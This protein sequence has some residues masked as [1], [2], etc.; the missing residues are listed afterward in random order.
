MKKD[1]W[2]ADFP[3]RNVLFREFLNGHME[4]MAHIA[5]TQR[6]TGD[7]EAWERKVSK[8]GSTRSTA[9]GTRKPADMS[10]IMDK[11]EPL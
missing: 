3:M 1:E 9:R 2:D 4:R 11:L 6:L 10:W 7:R 5:A 8:R